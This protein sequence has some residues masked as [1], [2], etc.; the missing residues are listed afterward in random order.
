M[1]NRW[2]F[3]LLEPS[4]QGLQPARTVILSAIC[5]GFSRSKER[6]RDAAPCNGTYNASDSTDF[7]GAN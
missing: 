3:N 4:P 5:D 7:I 1:V 6:A 2:V